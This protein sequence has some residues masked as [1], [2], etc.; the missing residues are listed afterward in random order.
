MQLKTL[1][2]V[3]AASFTFNIDVI[4]QVKPF[5]L[6]QQ[7]QGRD[8]DNSVNDKNYLARSNKVDNT[9]SFYTTPVLGTPQF[10]WA[11]AKIKNFKKSTEYISFLKQR[12]IN[13]NSGNR[14]KNI[15]RVAGDYYLK[16]YSELLGYKSQNG[17]KLKYKNSTQ[18]DKSK[19]VITSY[20]QY[21]N[22]TPLLGSG[23][24][25]LMDKN[26]K[27]ISVSSTLAPKTKR[28]ASE[29]DFKLKK[30]RAISI[31]LSDMTNSSFSSDFVR[32][33][34]TNEYSTQE[35][36]NGWYTNKSIFV[37]KFY[38]PQKDHVLSAYRVSAHLSKDN[39]EAR[40]RE[41]P[42]TETRYFGYVISA[43]DGKILQKKDYNTKAFH[44]GNSDYSYRVYADTITKLPQDGPD[45]N[46][47]SPHPT[48][49]PDGFQ[50]AYGVQ[51]LLTLR[52]AGIHTQDPWLPARS[53][54]TVGNNVDAYLD[55]VTPDGFT[56]NSADMRGK[57][58]ANN[59]FNYV[60]D[61][62]IAANATTTQKQAAV[63]NLFY[64]I[65]YLHD[66]FYNAGFDEA[67]GNAQRNNYGRGGR[68]NDPLLAEGQDYSGVNNANMS[69][70]PDG[71][72]PIM[73]QYIFIGKSEQKIKFEPTDRLKLKTHVSRL[74]IQEVNTGGFI[75]MSTL[76][77]STQ[78]I[79]KPFTNRIDL[80]DKIVIANLTKECSPTDLYKA[81]KSLKPALVMLVNPNVLPRRLEA[82]LPYP[83]IDVQSG[84]NTTLNVTSV[85]SKE[86]IRA[87]YIFKKYPDRDS[88]LSNLV[89][90]HEWGHY[91][92]G[93]LVGNGVG[94]DNS[95]YG[96][97]MGEGFS[98]FIALMHMVREEDLG[99]PGGDNFNGLYPQGGWVDGSPSTS[100]VNNA[101]YWGIRRL[102]YTRD[103][104]KN[105]L[106]YRH[107]RL[108]E[109]LPTHHP[110]KGDA[111]KVTE[112]GAHSQ[113]EIWATAL[114]E[115]F[116]GLARDTDRLTLDQAK[117]RMRMYLVSGMKLTPS[118][119][120]Y[121]MARD[122]IIASAYANDIEDAKI[123]AK[124]FAKRGMG[125]GATSPSL[126]SKDLKVGLTESF[127]LKSYAL[128]KSL[129][130]L[131]LVGKCDGDEIWDATEILEFDLT[132]YNSGLNTLPAGNLT[133]T[134][135][136][137]LTFVDSNTISHSKLEPYQKQ[138]G[139]KFKV[140]LSHD[141]PAFKNVSFSVA[142]SNKP[143]NK[144]AYQFFTNHDFGLSNYENF[145]DSVD[146][147]VSKRFFN[148]TV[149]NGKDAPSDA[150]D[151]WRGG[152]NPVSNLPMA[153]QVIY[154]GNYDESLE[155]KVLEV[156]S[157]ADFEINYSAV[158]IQPNGLAGGML[159]IREE[160]GDWTQIPGTAITSSYQGKPLPSG[161]GGT[162]TAGPHAGKNAF[163][164][165]SAGANDAAPQKTVVNL[166]RSYVNKKVQIR[167][168]STASDHGKGDL[169][170][171]ELSKI[172]FKG[173]TNKVIDK[174]L[175]KNV[176]KCGLNVAPKVTLSATGG[177]FN[178][179]NLAVSAKSGDSLVIT[180]TATDANKEDK[181]TYLWKHTNSDKS[182]KVTLTNAD[183][184]KVK[185]DIPKTLAG[186][187]NLTLTV[188]DGKAE[189][190]SSAI[191]TVTKA[192]EKPKKK[193]KK[194]GGTF[195]F[196]LGL[197]L[198]GLG[199]R[200]FRKLM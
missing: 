31:A 89:V 75:A 160:G 67:S 85:V 140:K 145:K 165:V 146:N 73:Q 94:S 152:N 144:T 116:M 2:F 134:S 182:G 59:E 138:E 8:N 24:N 28:K 178:N 48:G 50:P 131:S 54:E 171:W 32:K 12:Q 187:V 120:T 47:G 153:A 80:V 87:S 70:P 164:G 196:S 41:T 163:T 44:G 76:N 102:P 43:S 114:F 58:N 149:T 107:V 109:T 93:R 157:D 188:S 156:G 133:L 20:K 143:E 194:S 4:A 174:S 23:V 26:H 117:A 141:S 147:Y 197:L 21:V 184:A 168:R 199:L 82:Q 14:S 62:T 52:H 65:N 34:E 97:G 15:N 115:A 45:G 103:M 1:T 86:K 84:K 113:G 186:I 66:V 105:G 137:K 74:G 127:E 49:Q 53:T 166:G 104:S 106:T 155:S 159:E 119:A 79:C 95:V 192:E 7:Q 190:T 132:A 170:V 148:W 13:Y 161:Y 29:Q 112:V 128:P 177:S 98:D 51:N 19:P 11:N 125:T 110:I 92:H 123:I 172:E 16:Q 193:K 61:A 139:L 10:F 88:T 142:P 150:Y 55:L 162:I 173:L 69:T 30:N 83:V 118:A 176:K 167:F 130:R 124:G 126:S 189:T 27:L 81:L 200:K 158:Y 38:Y 22:G 99:K 96:G 46:N 78:D 185:L 39:P 35:T 111:T 191:V 108:G 90:M 57:V 3:I 91:L 33:G 198:A 42:I 63:T 179:N 60:F 64:T 154:T 36:Q 121:L 56:K 17:N 181:L 100:E 135:T 101:Y 72:S 68:E 129:K 180:A 195:F 77:N 175:I 18:V 25:F 122:A 169:T 40:G 5:D 183:S 9:K 37:E 6:L 136:D 71:Q 151:S